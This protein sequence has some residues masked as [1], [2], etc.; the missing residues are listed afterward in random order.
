VVVRVVP[1]VSIAGGIA[2][3]AGGRAV[4]PVAPVVVAVADRSNR[5]KGLDK[6]RGCVLCAAPF[7]FGA[8][9]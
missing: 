8:Q 4:V 9:A 6:Q 7:F 1:A 3:A 2:A 5:S